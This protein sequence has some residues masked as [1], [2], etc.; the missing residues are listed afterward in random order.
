MAQENLAFDLPQVSHSA[1]AA[2]EGNPFREQYGICR[3]C[4]SGSDTSH[5]H[6][7]RTRLFWCWQCHLTGCWECYVHHQ[8]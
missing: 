8:C 4:G 2:G 1:A 3:R 5:E 7:Q 6:E